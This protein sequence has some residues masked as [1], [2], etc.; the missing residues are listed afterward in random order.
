MPLASVARRLADLNPRVSP[1]TLGTGPG[2]TFS[3]YIEKEVPQPQEE[4]ALGFS[5]TKRA[6][7]SSSV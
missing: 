5:I 3:A 1:K 4:V 6:P 2:G 7:I